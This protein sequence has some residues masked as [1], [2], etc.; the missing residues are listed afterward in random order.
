[1][2]INEQI[3]E[4]NE[5]VRCH[6]KPSPIHGIGVFALRDIKKGERCYCFPNQFR[7]WYNVPY[8]KL[9]EL[10]PEIKAI[11][12]DRWPSIINKSMFQS[13]NDDVWLASFINHSDHF[14]YDQPSDLALRD[15]TA[16]EEITENYRPMKG[17]EQIYSFLKETNAHSPRTASHIS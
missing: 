4:L 2:D 7:K 10:R 3:R 14:N 11:I 6:L 17:A 1:M 9:D 13:P 12:L 5:E 15:I 16:G 8:E